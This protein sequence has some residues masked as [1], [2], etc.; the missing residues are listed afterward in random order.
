MSSPQE[1]TVDFRAVGG[2]DD[3]TPAAQ[4]GRPSSTQEKI[5]LGRSSPLKMSQ[6]YAAVSMRFTTLDS[7]CASVS[8]RTCM[9]SCL[10]EISDRRDTHHSTPPPMRCILRTN[11]DGCPPLRR[12]PRL[13]TLGPCL[14]SMCDPSL[15]VM[16]RFPGYLKM[17]LTAGHPRHGCFR[18]CPWTCDCLARTP[19]SSIMVCLSRRGPRPTTTVPVHFGTIISVTWSHPYLRPWAPP[20][21]PTPA[22]RT[23]MAAHIRMRIRTVAHRSPTPSTQPP[24]PVLAPLDLCHNPVQLLSSRRCLPPPVPAPSWHGCGHNT[25]NARTNVWP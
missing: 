19:R 23:M 18:P 7:P 10:S 3:R 16:V 14:S 17:I 8:M 24:P 2:G 5:K 4:D 13:S 20:P 6:M 9:W 1:W 25:S 11:R 12:D 21:L 22:I 15:A